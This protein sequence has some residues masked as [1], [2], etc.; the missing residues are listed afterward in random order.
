MTIPKI[1]NFLSNYLSPINSSLVGRKMMGKF[2]HSR[3]KSL[4][5]V[6]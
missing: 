4:M 6:F 1:Q 3:K 5:D 2:I